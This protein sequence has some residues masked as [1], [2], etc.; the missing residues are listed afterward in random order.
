[1]HPLRHAYRTTSYGPESGRGRGAAH[2]LRATQSS[3]R[4][5]RTFLPLFARRGTNVQ[6][7][8][9]QLLRTHFARTP[10]L[11]HAQPLIR[12]SPSLSVL[13]LFIQSRSEMGLAKPGAGLGGNTVSRSINQTAHCLT[14]VLSAP[15]RNGV[16]QWCFAGGDCM[17]SGGSVHETKYLGTWTA[18]S[19]PFCGRQHPPGPQRVR[20]GCRLLSCP[21]GERKSSAC[22]QDPKVPRYPPLTPVA[23]SGC[24]FFS[25]IHSLLPAPAGA[26]CHCCWLL[27]LCPHTPQQVPCKH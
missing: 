3:T 19:S 1:M 8:A 16:L 18:P 13:C 7:H 6:Q 26:G 20:V 14:T 21:V 4:L 25:A 10:P 5:H 11:R 15:L 24:T 23:A 22:R 9:S 27:L 12:V 17:G 2:L